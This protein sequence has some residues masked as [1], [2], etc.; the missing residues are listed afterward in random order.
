VTQN[1]TRERF[2]IELEKL[3]TWLDFNNLIDLSKFDWLG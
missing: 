3:L 2:W 1:G